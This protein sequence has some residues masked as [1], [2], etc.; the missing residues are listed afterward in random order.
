MPPSSA[1]RSG[2]SFLLSLALAAAPVTA[3]AQSQAPAVVAP[4]PVGPLPPIVAPRWDHGGQF[5]IRVGLSE[6]YRFVV[7]YHDNREA[8]PCDETDKKFCTGLSPLMLDTTLGF[9]VTR[10][11]ELDAR[12]RMGLLTD[13]DGSRPMQAG[14]GIRSM[15][16]GSARLKFLLAASVLLDFTQDRLRAG[17][18]FDVVARAE[19]GL[20]W[21]AT[22]WVG[23]YASLGESF[24]LLRNFSCVVDLS[25]GVQ[26]RV[27][28]GQ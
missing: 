14:I 13:F 17:G 2:S 19:E 26:F 28:P 15:G 25:L 21:D 12:F 16:D 27:P 6:G 23:V 18:D 8:D 20:Q 3:F 11:L 5:G 1:M 10:G 7:R 4:A 22:R 9:G 24:G